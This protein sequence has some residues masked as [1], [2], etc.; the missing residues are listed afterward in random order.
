MRKSVS[1]STFKSVRMKK[2]LLG[3]VIVL[4]TVSCSSKKIVYKESAPSISI[5][6]NPVELITDPAAVSYFSIT[7]KTVIYIN[8]SDPD[9]KKIA[10]YLADI[11]KPASGFELKVVQSDSPMS[12][13]N[14]YFKLIENPE[15]H[16]EGYKLAV[17]QNNIVLEASKPSGL[18]Y[19]VQT[20][21]QLLPAEIEKKDLQKIPWKIRT[22]SI[23][24]FPRYKWRGAMLD[25]ARHFFDVSDV[26]RYIDYLAFYKMNVFHLHLSDDQ[27]WRIEIKSWPNL[28]AIGASTAV[29]GDRGG[30]FTQEDYKDIVK[31][32]MDRYITVIPEVDFP[33]HS[34]AALASYGELNCD[35]LPTELYTG[36]KV[37][38]SSLCIDKEITYKF[39][40][41]VIGEIAAI[42][43]GPYIHIGGD[44]ARS[45]EEEDYIKFIN[46]VEKIVKENGKKMI[47]WEEIIKADIASNT[48]MQ[49][50][51]SPRYASEAQ[52]KG[53]NMIYSPSTKIYL[54]MKYNEDIK[55]G[56]NWAG[57]TD[58]KK[59]YSW[60]PDTEVPGVFGNSIIGVEAPLWT[61]TIKTFNDI[62][63]MAFPRI[64][65]A[66]EIGWSQKH[67]RNWENYKKRFLI[68]SD[69]L[70]KMNIKYYRSS[71]LN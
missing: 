60:D 53:I 1:I 30:Y 65:G 47:G 52:N 34:N 19:G 13:G 17:T 22:V 54:D 20:I 71:Q 67:M 57:Y 42:T 45:T 38:F 64:I 5:I 24:D 48:L 15:L 11:I 8:S 66:A 18:F 29:D 55:L 7:G 40:E 43:P 70:D 35:G 44:E 68:H 33:G 51:N 31:Y 61:E 41:D 36:I 27:G 63:Y 10:H 69:R 56:L 12:K 50:W 3:A 58:V 2:L 39:I 9:L 46:R 25:V 59:S 21:R 16:K 26:K 49:Y 23:K 6:P 37:G 14:I 4:F 62:Q 32:A 28:T